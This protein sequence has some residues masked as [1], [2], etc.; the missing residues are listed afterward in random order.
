GPLGLSLARRLVGLRW[1][2]SGR[3]F[4][5][6]G[7]VADRGGAGGLGAGDVGRG[8]G[9]LLARAVLGPFRRDA[10]GRPGARPAVLASDAQAQE[11]RLAGADPL[12]GPAVLE[13]G[14]QM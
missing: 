14:Q 13:P 7:L 8:L 6:G 4:G 5:A 9:D 10:V 1:C 12:V 2:V 11:G 3:P